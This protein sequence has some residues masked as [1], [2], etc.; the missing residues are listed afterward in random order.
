MTINPLFH[1]L[2][3]EKQARIIN[4]ALQEFVRSG[5]ERAST[6]EIVKEANI[7]KGSLFN[8]FNNKKNLYIYLIDYAVQVIEEIYE[9]IDWHE[10]DLFTRIEKIGLTKLQFQK[11]FP[12]VFD[13]LTS[14]IHESSAEVEEVIKQRFDA[15]YH[16]GI[17]K[18]YK[19]IDDSKFRDDIDIQKAIEI[20]NWTMIGF[21]EKA[22][23]QLSTFEEVGDVYL[24]EWRDYCRILKYSFYK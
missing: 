7:S 16:E 15:I 4:A 12:Q 10:A 22:V 18:I 6:N 24:E 20:L 17:T 9:Q 14:L 21:R 19:N 11:Q 1:S 23:H 13:F 3:S 2:D 8:Y 5:Y